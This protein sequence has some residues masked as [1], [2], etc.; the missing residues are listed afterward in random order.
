M[1]TLQPILLISRSHPA[2]PTTSKLAGGQLLIVRIPYADEQRYIQAAIKRVAGS[3]FRIIQ[4]E[5]RPTFVP[6]VRRAFPRTPIVLSL[7]S[8][9]FMSR[10][11]TTRAQQIVKQTNRVVSV[12]SFLTDEMK[13]RFP[14]DAKKFKTAQPGVNLKTFRPQSRQF[15]QQLRRSWGV[16]GTFNIL[17][18]GRIVHGK[19]LHTLVKAVA[20]LKQRYRDVRLIAIGSSW[21]GISKQTPYMRRIRQLS[22]RLGVPIL[23]T[24]YIP[25][26]RI[27]ALYHLGDV[28]VCPSIY[29]EGF[30]LVNTEAMASGI[31]VIASARGGI[32]KM[33]KHGESGFLVGAYQSPRTFA[34][35]LAQLKQSPE[36]AKR[37]AAGGRQR[38]IEEFGWD[39]RV[40]RLLKQYRS[41]R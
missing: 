41:I 20:L 25:P 30:G 13:R 18:V 9:T 38:V 26:K 4:I 31:P 2:L 29:R 37:L 23:F 28:L 7:H 3:A 17:F 36:L 39:D 1:S 12:S 24:G 32:R 5:N 16:D 6:Y 34:K 10:L 27:A 21:P 33:I 19:G 8:L 35:R 15:K 14:H 11:S 22:M 40:K